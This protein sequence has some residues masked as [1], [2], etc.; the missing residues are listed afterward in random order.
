MSFTNTLTRLRPVQVVL[1]SWTLLSFVLAVLPPDMGG[2]VRALNAVLF[3]TLGP[4][5]ALFLLLLEYMPPAEAAVVAI[6]TS[7]VTLVLGS[8]VLLIM[9]FWRTWGVTGIVA[10][11]TAAL[12]LL[13]SLRAVGGDAR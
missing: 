6:G 10:L 5:C 1:L 11:V 12:T 2:T 8:Q 7:L 4:G 13:P 3:I 9:G